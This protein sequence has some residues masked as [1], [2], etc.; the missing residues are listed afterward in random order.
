MIPEDSEMMSFQ[1]G[2]FE[3][4]FQ[5]RCEVAL[6]SWKMGDKLLDS[7]SGPLALSSNASS[8]DLKD[9]LSKRGS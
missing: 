3:Q 2:D 8:I 1:Q 7:Q 9:F 4:G 6:Q 5:R